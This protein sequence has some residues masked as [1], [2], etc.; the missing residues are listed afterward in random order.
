MDRSADKTL[1]LLRELADRREPCTEGENL[2]PRTELCRQA[3]T[4]ASSS[5]DPYLEIIEETLA[6]NEKLAVYEK[7]ADDQSA[8]RELRILLAR[9]ANWLRITARLRATGKIASGFES[10]KIGASERTHLVDSAEALLFSPIRMAG[11]LRQRANEASQKVLKRPKQPPGLTSKSLKGAMVSR[12]RGRSY[13][14]ARR[15]RPRPSMW[16]A[17]ALWDGSGRR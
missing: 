9:R 10:E 2:L 13:R 8:A 15:S 6:V 4:R 5:T 7:V 11:N 14:Q 16:R 3:S 1:R 17:W 12:V